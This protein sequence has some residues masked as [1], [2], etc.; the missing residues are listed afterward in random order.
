MVEKE[1]DIFEI[2]FKKEEVKIEE[3]E[4]NLKFEVKNRSVKDEEKTVV[5]TVTFFD[6]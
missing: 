3:E 2:T 6:R 1:E 4:E 5:K